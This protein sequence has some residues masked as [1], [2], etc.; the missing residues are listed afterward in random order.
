MAG[1]MKRL[2]HR[3]VS[4]W[5]DLQA[6]LE[7]IRTVEFILGLTREKPRGGIDLYAAQ[8]QLE[9]ARATIGRIALAF[10]E[11]GDS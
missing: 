7:H 9:D 1:E 11:D 8:V 3:T 10:A 6:A 5:T 4:V 2:S